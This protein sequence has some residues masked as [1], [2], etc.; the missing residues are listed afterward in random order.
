MM[1]HNEY[2]YMY[3]L[4]WILQQ[5]KGQ[6]SYQDDTGVIACDM[7]CEFQKYCNPKKS[8]EIEVFIGIVHIMC[9]K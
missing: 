4:F 5:L 9:I 6:G 8:E 2:L 7:L 1:C 3:L